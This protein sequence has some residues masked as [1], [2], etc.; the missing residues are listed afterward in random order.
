[1][2][3]PFDLSGQIFRACTVAE[4]FYG[5]NNFLLVVLFKTSEKL[6]GSC[7]KDRRR[8]SLLQGLPFAFPG[9]DHE[10]HH[11]CTILISVVMQRG[12]LVVGIAY[13][14]PYYKSPAIFHVF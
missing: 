8:L 4:A 3:K 7:S 1:M 14:G 11:A 5:I 2:D 9:V 13:G 6:L 12:A 10:G